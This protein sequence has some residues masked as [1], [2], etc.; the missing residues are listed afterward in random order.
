MSEQTV[1]SAVSGG[2]VSLTPQSI[3]ELTG[4]VRTDASAGAAR[5]ARASVAIPTAT[6]AQSWSVTPLAPAPGTRRSHARAAN[7]VPA[8]DNPRG[9]AT[10]KSTSS[11]P[12]ELQAAVGSKTCTTTR[13]PLRLGQVGSFSGVLGPINAGGRTGLAVWAKAANAR[14]GVDCQPVQ[15]FVVD[16]GAD[17]SRTAAAVQNLVED[18]NVVALVGT[19]T[20]LTETALKE[21]AEKYK[22]PVV[23][24]DELAFDWNSSPYMFPEGAG[25]REL[26]FGL[27]KQAAD[28]GLTKFG[29]LYCVETPQCTTLDSLGTGKLAGEAGVTVVSNQPVSITQA[30]FTAQCQNAKNAG[31]QVLGVA[32]DGSTIARMV[33]S[34]KALGYRPPIVTGAA[35]LSPENAA[36]P[37]IRQNTLL[38]A[39]IVAPWM[40][41]DTAGQRAYQAAMGAYAPGA[42][43]DSDSIEAWTSGKLSETA[44][45]HLDPSLTTP[46]ATDVLAGLRRI[47]GE[48]LDGLTPPITFIP[49][50]PAPEIPCIYFIKLDELGWTAPRGTHPVCRTTG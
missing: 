42:P 6:T 50:K 43:L 7:T 20:T 38:S 30:D 9:A 48:T 3:E 22:V 35:I 45:S 16:D 11:S 4:A 17:P 18:K 12:D 39:G 46:T 49:G 37:D 28:A 29:F 40:L 2:Q 34:C 36:D 8:R 31:A 24:G 47:K 27:L 1:Q 32:A 25:L 19:F 14:G 10:P 23:G 26:A 5:S 15:L 21:A 44:M 13:A 41:S 33:R